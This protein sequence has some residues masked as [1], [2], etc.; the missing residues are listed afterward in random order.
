MTMRWKMTK[1]TRWTTTKT[2]KREEETDEDGQAEF[3]D[4]EDGEYAVG[5]EYEGEQ[6]VDE[7]E[8]DGAD[9]EITLTLGEEDD[10][11]DDGEDDE[12]DGV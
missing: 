8:I 2:P 12:D 7:V 1:T 9:E 10:E 5:A 4:L 3:E 11:M 6:A